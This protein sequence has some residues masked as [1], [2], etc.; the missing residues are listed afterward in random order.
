MKRMCLLPLSRPLVKAD[1]SKRLRRPP[2]PHVTP[3]DEAPAPRAPN[4]ELNPTPT[5]LAP[6]RRSA[7]GPQTAERLEEEHLEVSLEVDEKREI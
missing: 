1:N 7:L 2:A 4:Q 3:P 5:P 6:R